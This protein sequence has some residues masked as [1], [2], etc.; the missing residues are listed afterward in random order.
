MRSFA[1]EVQRSH[2]LGQGV[3]VL[4]RRP[5]LSKEAGFFASM[6]LMSGHLVRTHTYVCDSL[7]ACDLRMHTRTQAN[8]LVHRFSDTGMRDLRLLDSLGAPSISLKQGPR[9]LWGLYR[10]RYQHPEVVL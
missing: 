3:P 4:R 10:G 9:W 7:R 5:D 6:L 8:L 1:S 2:G